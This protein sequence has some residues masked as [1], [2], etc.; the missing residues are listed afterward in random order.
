MYH[1]RRDRIINNPHISTLNPLSCEAGKTLMCRFEEEP[2]QLISWEKNWTVEKKW[3]VV[4]VEEVTRQHAILS[5]W[6]QNRKWQTKGQGRVQF[7]SKH[8]SQKDITHLGALLVGCFKI[9]K[10]S[11]ILFF[12]WN[13]RYSILGK[14][15]TK[16][17]L[18]IF[19]LRVYKLISSLSLNRVLGI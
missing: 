1:W 7:Q 2:Q 17:N 14:T 12:P 6:L 15:F 11:Q 4:L 10:V 18:D 19:S 16:P 13:P 5:D 8:R 3:Q 9:A